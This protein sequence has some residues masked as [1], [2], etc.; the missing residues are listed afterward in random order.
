MRPSDPKAG[1]SIRRAASW[2]GAAVS[3]PACAR[4]NRSNTTRSSPCRRTAAS[5]HSATC[6]WNASARST[7]SPKLPPSSPSGSAAI[8]SPAWSTVP[9]PITPSIRKT[10]IVSELR[11]RRRFLL[12]AAG[13]AGLAFGL[14]VSAHAAPEVRHRPIRKAP[15]ALAPLPVE[16][17]KT[18]VL[19]FGVHA[20]GPEDGHAIILLHDFFHDI[21]S[22]AEVAGLLAADGYRVVVPYL[23][24]HGSTRFKDAATPRSGQLAALGS[25]VIA[26]MDAMHIPEAVV[27]GSGWGARAACAMALLRPTRCV[28]LVTA[29]A[30]LYDD[31]VVADANLWKQFDL[32]SEAGRNALNAHRRDVARRLWKEGSPQR[33][34]DAAAFARSAPSFDNPDFAEVVSHAYCHRRG[35]AAGDPAY[36]AAEAKLTTRRPLAAPSIALDGDASG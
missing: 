28:G 10:R 12:G 16:P 1:C 7:A 32:Q 34:L 19:S 13:V 15:P 20:A 23:R 36:D 6:W 17:V 26:I 30:D 14:P 5:T 22:F 8:S 11:S 21:H 33:E 3:S 27:G 35:L 18:D 4:W 2:C 9:R 29:G 24:G 25:D 31:P